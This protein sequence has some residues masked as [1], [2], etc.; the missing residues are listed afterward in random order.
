MVV[1]TVV[2]MVALTVVL[3]VA[4]SVV[5]RATTQELVM[6]DSLV[7]EWVVGWVD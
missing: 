2:L 7:R 5:L 3:M 1:V 6:V 4:L